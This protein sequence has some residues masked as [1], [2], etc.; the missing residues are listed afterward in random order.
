[1]TLD[2]IV[3]DIHALEEDMGTYERKY[4]V[5]SETF[6]AAY[7]LGEEP[8][9]TA[10]VA[11]WNDW[12]AVHEIWVDRRQRYQS[13]IETLQKQTGLIDLIRRAAHRESIPV[14]A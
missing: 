9:E 5:L 1:M 13:A 3:Q 7:V 6:Y 8:P 2:E 12:A 14:P 11:D 4:G 10:W